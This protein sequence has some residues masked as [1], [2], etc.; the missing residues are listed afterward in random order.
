MLLSRTNGYRVVA[1][2]HID[3][4]LAAAERRIALLSRCQPLD[5][6]RERARLLERHAR[7]QALDPS[8]RYAPPPSLAE[9]R[10]ALTSAADRLTAGGP[11][12]LLYAERCQELA[13]EAEL[14]EQVGTRAFRGLS[15]RRYP[16]PSARAGARAEALA[17][18]WVRATTP[19]H[20]RRVD[21]AD[22]RDPDS[23]LCVLQRSIGQLRLAYR[24]QLEHRLA[25]VAATG[26]GVVYVRP[27]VA[28]TVRAAQRIGVHELVGHALPRARAVAEPI[29]LL[30]VGSARADEDEEGRALVLEA[31]GGF[32]DDERRRALGLRHLCAS[33]LAGGSDWTECVR[34]LVAHGCAPAEAIAL[35]ER[36]DRGGGL[37]RE[38]IYLPAYE[39]LSRTLEQEPELERWLSRGRLSASAARTIA[40]L[41]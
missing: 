21:S 34:G 38:L 1:L 16:A 7:G 8:Y 6:E 9:L 41:P 23:L 10:Q 17:R 19:V 29:G 2:P 12:E 28:L 26:D 11:L 20:E 3:R 25:S 24:V 40:A 33:W 39:R 35:C 13:L 15:R 37:C 5:A 32:L 18:A 14:A 36:A 22:E 27:G 31:R 30:R 4:L